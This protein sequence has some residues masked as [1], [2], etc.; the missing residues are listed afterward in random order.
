M[1]KTEEETVDIK[2]KL[3]EKCFQR[4]SPLLYKRI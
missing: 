2:Y 3:P 1:C 4:Q